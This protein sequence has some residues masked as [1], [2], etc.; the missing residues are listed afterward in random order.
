MDMADVI[1]FIVD[2]KEGMTTADEEVGAMLQR[3]GKKVILLVNK[4][5]N[6]GNPTENI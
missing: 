6:P 1:L 2:G 5:D 4:V 3:T